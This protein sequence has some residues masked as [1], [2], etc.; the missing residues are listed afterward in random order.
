MCTA[1]MTLLA[2]GFK[3]MYAGLPATFRHVLAGKYRMPAWR[4]VAGAC[5]LTT[6]V[7][8]CPAASAGE[9]LELS[10]TNHGGEYNLR[11]SALLD[12]PENYVYKVITDY[13]HVYRLNPSITS[14]DVLPSDDGNPVRVQHYSRH[15][16]GPFSYNV[17]WAGDIVESG[18]HSLRIT[19]IPGSSSFDSGSALWE[20]SALDNRS[21]VLHESSMKPKLFIP[22]IIGSHIMK[23]HMRKETLAI[24]DRIEHLAQALR[25]K[26]T[27]EDT[28]QL[29]LV[30]GD[31]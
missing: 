3:R 23:Q 16:I 15:R 7:L 22:P 29:K 24:F 18:H 4:P 5:T 11:I 10:V 9:I 17:A 21:Y 13:R 2:A 31:N 1:I 6:L 27:E 26:N 28:G 30:S 19:T 14:V 12:A 25:N 8:L 20:V